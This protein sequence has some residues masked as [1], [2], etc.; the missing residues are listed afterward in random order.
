MNRTNTW[1]HRFYDG[2]LRGAEKKDFA[3]EH[4][5]TAAI[6]H[7]RLGLSTWKSHEAII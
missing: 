4:Q 1:K 5:L 2:E 7:A 6:A 3:G